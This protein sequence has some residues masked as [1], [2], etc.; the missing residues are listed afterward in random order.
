MEKMI[1]GLLLVA[2]LVVIGIL[3]LVLWV[4]KRTVQPR[5]VCL[6]SPPT[7]NDLLNA[8]VQVE[9]E[10]NE[11][12]IGANGERGI[13]QLSEIYID[14]VNR[15]LGPSLATKE[16]VYEYKD[17]FNP[18]YSKIMVRRYLKHYLNVAA[19]DKPSEMSTFEMAA[20]IHNGGPHGWKKDSTKAYWKKVEARL[21]AG[22]VQE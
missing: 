19:K 15:I 5:S 20:R 11:I 7:F 6:S 4:N 12:A 8:M 17:A 14:D 3:S 9:S 22:S 21:Y 1:I 13:L 10:D 16:A 18:K 2:L